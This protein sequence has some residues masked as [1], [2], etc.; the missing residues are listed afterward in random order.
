MLTATD[1]GKG[2]QGQRLPDHLVSPIGGAQHT[3]AFFL[4]GGAM[5]RVC[6]TA[7]SSNRA[8]HHGPHCSQFRSCSLSPLS[9]CS[10]GGGG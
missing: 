7:I 2:T 9:E 6:F 10:G 3:Q 1:V 4:G 5:G 8:C